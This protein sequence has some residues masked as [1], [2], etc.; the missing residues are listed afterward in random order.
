[1]KIIKFL[2]FV[3]MF[4]L[5]GLLVGQ[6]RQLTKAVEKNPTIVYKYIEPEPVKYIDEQDLYLKVVDFKT[7]KG[8][9]TPA[10]DK[11]LCKYAELRIGTLPNN[12]SHD[13][14]LENWEY[15]IV[16]FYHRSENLAKGHSSAEKVLDSWMKSPPHLQVLMTNDS[17]L[18]IR[19]QN[20]NGINYC[21][22]ESAY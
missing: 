21:V 19:C 14:F 15:S 22:Y 2:A 9:K 3:I 1:M 11:S 18:C 20:I 10:V 12:W 17:Y 6:N 7:T 16:P 8:L 5:L 4:S 13:I